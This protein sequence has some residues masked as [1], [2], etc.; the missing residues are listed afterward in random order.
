MFYGLPNCISS[1]FQKNIYDFES[2][3]KSVNQNIIPIKLN[4][5]VLHNEEEKPIGGVISFR[6]ISDIERINQDLSKDSNFY[7]IIGK[8]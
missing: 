8:K 2:K 7:G 1:K 5:A 6:E 4:A 3:I